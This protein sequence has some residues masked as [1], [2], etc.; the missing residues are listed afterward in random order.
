MALPV[1]EKWY[2][3]RSCGDGVTLFYEPHVHDWLRP[4]IWHIRGRDKNILFDSGMG[5]V[6]L[7]DELS[8]HLEKDILA[9][10]SHTHFDHIG[11]HYEFENRACH[12]SEAFVLETP[13][14]DNTLA[15]NFLDRDQ[16]PAL[17]YSEE[18]L[19]VMNHPNIWLSGLPKAGYNV[20]TEYAVRPAPPTLL[21]DEG[22]VVDLGD[23]MFQVLHL[24]GHSPS[25]IAL[26][27]DATGIFLTGDA[28]LNT[29]RGGPLLDSYDHSD[30]ELYVKT[31]LRIREMPVSVVHGGHC[32]S[33]G[34]DRMVEIAD[35]Y[36]ESKKVPVCPSAARKSL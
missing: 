15:N 25:S 7:H 28:I 24:P 35:I 36:I 11:G 22:D 6:P 19:T 21:L 16:F 27:E 32:E 18:D 14:N 13:N 31:M 8:E 26:F 17:G 10:A 34:R 4:N 29:T 3:T 5:I 23:R 9:I 12:P 30:P 20:Q 2:E 1:V 33:M